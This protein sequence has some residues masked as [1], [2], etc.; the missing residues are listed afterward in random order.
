[1]SMGPDGNLWM[2]YIATG[3]LVRLSYQGSMAAAA[4]TPA[5]K[6]TVAAS[7]TATNTVAI[8]ESLT[9]SDNRVL[10]TTTVAPTPTPQPR[11]GA[12]AGEITRARTNI[13]G[14]HIADLTG[15]VAYPDT[16]D[17]VDTLTNCM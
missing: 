13:P 8:T 2:L 14:V 1:M 5:P 15:S 11:S 12:G 3:E 17:Q 7:T 16:P 10:L 9:V 6:A 4:A